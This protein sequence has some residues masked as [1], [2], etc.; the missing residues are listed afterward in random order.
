MNEIRAADYKA[1]TKTTHYVSLA[2]G[3][4]FAIIVRAHDCRKRRESLRNVVASEQ[5]LNTVC[6]CLGVFQPLGL[7]RHASCRSVPITVPN[8]P[9]CTQVTSTG[10]WHT[11][12]LLHVHGPVDMFA[13]NLFKKAGNLRTFS[14]S[15][16]SFYPKLKSHSGAK[17]RWKAIANGH[18]KRV[19]IS[20]LNHFLRL[21]LNGFP[22]TRN[23]QAQAAHHHLNVSKRPG[24]KNQLAQTAYS[25]STQT[26][27][28]HKLL[29][30]GS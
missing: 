2:F 4:G 18:F 24:R 20:F 13:L 28:L 27:K 22:L 30:Y 8:I 10:H 16:A 17:K 23:V 6:L 12:T 19:R 15:V 14:T 3:G 21:Q 7:S 26:T 25:T 29:P 5:S 11:L 9:F 1:G